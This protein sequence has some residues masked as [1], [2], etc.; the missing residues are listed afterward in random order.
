[1]SEA[2]RLFNERCFGELRDYAEE[3]ERENTVLREMSDKA[4]TI[5]IKRPIYRTLLSEN[6]ARK[7]Q[8]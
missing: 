2:H 4:D 1:M 3:L 8:P 6:A 5:T 7:E